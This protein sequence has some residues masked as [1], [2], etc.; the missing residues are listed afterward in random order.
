MHLGD[1]LSLSRTTKAFRELVLA[2]SAERFWKAAMENSLAEGLPACPEWLSEP[3]YANLM[4]SPH[5]HVRGFFDLALIL[6][7][8]KSAT[9][10]SLRKRSICILRLGCAL[11][12][13]MPGSVRPSSCLEYYHLLTL[14]WG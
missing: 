1:L 8:L 14:C 9:E 2:R 7:T 13:E 6:L 12:Q 4:Y 11:L 10:L 5:C 3:A